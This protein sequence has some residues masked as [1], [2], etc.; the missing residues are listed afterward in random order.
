MENTRILS[1]WCDESDGT[2]IKVYYSRQRLYTVVSTRTKRWMVFTSTVDTNGYH[3]YTISW[4][5]Q[6]G[7]SL[8][9]NGDK[10]A[11][12]R[13]PERREGRTSTLCNLFIGQTGSLFSTFSLELVNIV[14]APIDIVNVIGLT[15]GIVLI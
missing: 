15:T 1:T 7:L 3:T 10:N 14:Y 2:G 6:T 12:V 4:S 11:E 8:Y 5:Q 9:V 13:N